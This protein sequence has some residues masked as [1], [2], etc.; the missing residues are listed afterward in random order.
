V[1]E[2]DDAH[3]T[4]VELSVVIPCRDVEQTLEA[5]LDAVLSQSWEGAWEVVVV[6][7]GSRDSTAR[8]VKLRA[9]HEPRLRLVRAFER[10]GISY[11]RNAGIQA[12]HSPSIALC[13]GDDVVAPGWVAAMGDALR[14]HDYVAGALSV[15]EL[16]PPW[17]VRTRGR[18]APAGSATYF[19]IFRTAP[20]C[21]VGFRRAAWELVGGFDEDFYP[22][23][24][25]KFALDLWQH[26]V[27]PYGAPG[28]VVHYRYR[29]EARTLWRQGRAYGKGRVHVSRVLKDRRLPVPP[30]FAGWRSWLWLVRHLVDLRCAHGRAAWCWVAGNR[31]GQLSGS[32][33]FRLIQL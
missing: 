18:P 11:A 32:I 1:Q 12:T 22:T 27:V 16:N 7:N 8:I 20:G 29:Q 30:P 21:N 23:E 5:Q 25:L 2:S 4:A 33:S 13:D 6:D 3:A 9:A 10:A 28:A 14:R 17:L 19:G 26:G 31:I 15:G 24:D